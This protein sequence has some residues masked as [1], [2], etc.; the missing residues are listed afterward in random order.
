MKVLS[1]EL[2]SGGF[3][4]GA[5]AAVK[6]DAGAAEESAMDAVPARWAVERLRVVYDERC[7]VCP[8]VICV[9]FAGQ[10]A[11]GLDCTSSSTISE[12]VDR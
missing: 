6:P 12:G 2:S 1:L 8:S 7:N 10:F 9:W 4:T 5:V 11:G 3:S